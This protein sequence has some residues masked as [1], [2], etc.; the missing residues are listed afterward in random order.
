MKTQPSQF[1]V[2]WETY[3]GHVLAIHFAFA[4]G[5]VAKTVELAP[6][7]Y[8]DLDARGNMLSVELAEPEHFDARALARLQKKHK[9]PRGLAAFDP[10]RIC[11]ASA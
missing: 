8:A 11:T 10:S 9:L 3:K 4:E 5:K 6:E 1:L 7:V 2:R